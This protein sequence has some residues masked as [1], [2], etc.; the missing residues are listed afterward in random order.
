MRMR[1]GHPHRRDAG[2]TGLIRLEVPEHLRISLSYDF[3]MSQTL[4]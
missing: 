3:L 2:C 4:I 1:L